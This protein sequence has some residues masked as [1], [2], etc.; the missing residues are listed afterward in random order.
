MTTHERYQVGDIQA[1]NKGDP[2]YATFEEAEIAALKLNADGD[3]S[4]I[5][6][7]DMQDES[8]ELIAIVY[9]GTV[10]RP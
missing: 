6:V 2:Y 5:G 10:Y 9:E 1:L 3:N 8:G 4:F 7:W